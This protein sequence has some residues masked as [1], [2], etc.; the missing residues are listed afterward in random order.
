MVYDPLVFPRVAHGM[1][2]RQ[3]KSIE[4]YISGNLHETT[5]NDNFL[6]NFSFSTGN[7]GSIDPRL[8]RV[9]QKFDSSYVERP[10]CWNIGYEDKQFKGFSPTENSLVDNGA[11]G[12]PSLASTR[13]SQSLAYYDDT[14]S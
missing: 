10:E 9:D 3:E 7:S 12:H 14:T 5:F 13:F 1:D 2:H 6:A 11:A 8:L 4:T